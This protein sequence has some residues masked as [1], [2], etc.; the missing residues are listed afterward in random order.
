MSFLTPAKCSFKILQQYSFSAVLHTGWFT[1]P[2]KNY[3]FYP[4]KKDKCNDCNLGS[5]KRE[6]TMRQSSNALGTPLCDKS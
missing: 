2:V 3:T 1:L 5:L 4:F 6:R